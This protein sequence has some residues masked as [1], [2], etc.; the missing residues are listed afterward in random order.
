MV[1]NGI[2]WS[3]LESTGEK[4]FH[5]HER[6]SQVAEIPNHRTG[7]LRKNVACVMSL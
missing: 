2:P 5:G 6:S 1:R 3:L 4:S 7:A